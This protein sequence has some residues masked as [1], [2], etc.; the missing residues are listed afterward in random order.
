MGGERQ[1]AID[2][3]GEMKEMFAMRKT[4][5]TSECCILWID[6]WMNEWIY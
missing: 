6:G 3:E 1:G 2:N 4:K 5:N